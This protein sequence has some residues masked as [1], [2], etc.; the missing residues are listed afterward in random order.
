MD[1]SSVHRI[2]KTLLNP[3]STIIREAKT[4]CDEDEMCGGFTFRGSRMM[5]REYNIYFFHIL[6]NIESERDSLKWI[7][8]KSEK[9][10]L[11]FPGIFTDTGSPSHWKISGNDGREKCIGK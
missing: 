3:H 9:Q 5:D 4:L 7:L 2:F 6:I 11:K 1:D 10:F 8:Y